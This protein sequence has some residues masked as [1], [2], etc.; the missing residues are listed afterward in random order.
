[1]PKARALVGIDGTN[2]RFCPHVEL[3]DEL[4][5]TPSFKCPRYRDAYTPGPPKLFIPN[6]PR[7]I[8]KKV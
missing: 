3:L 4:V 8:K 6:P 7:F 2:D 5:I 1:M